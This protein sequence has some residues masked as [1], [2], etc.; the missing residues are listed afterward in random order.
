VTNIGYYFVHLK[1]V[2]LLPA[3]YMA[4]GDLENYTCVLQSCGVYF[5]T[6]IF[7]EF[8]LKWRISGCHGDDHEE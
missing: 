4:L 1:L 7:L 8:L 5:E 2:R 3:E 6:F